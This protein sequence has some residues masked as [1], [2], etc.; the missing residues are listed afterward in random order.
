MNARGPQEVRM[1]PSAFPLLEG[2]EKHEKE[3]KPMLFTVRHENT[4]N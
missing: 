4:L 2:A 1:R 3:K